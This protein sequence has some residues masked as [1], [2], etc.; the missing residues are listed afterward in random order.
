MNGISISN[1]ASYSGLADW[2]VTE[3]ADFDGDG[4]AD[5]QWY[6]PTSGQTVIW[7]MN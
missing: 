3:I 7:W 1:I 5:L 4:K 6:S 2:T